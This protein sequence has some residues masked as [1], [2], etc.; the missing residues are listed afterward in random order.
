MRPAKAS[1]PLPPGGPAAGV[2]RTGARVRLRAWPLLALPF[3]AGPLLPLLVVAG[4]TGEPADGAGGGTGELTGEVL[5]SAAASLTDAFREVA[6]AFESANPGVTVTL[7]LAGSSA[8]RAQILEGAPVDVFAS[9]NLPVMEEVQDAGEAEG[10]PRVFTRN[11]LEI[12][13]PPGNPG[14]VSGLGDFARDELLVGLCAEAVP[15]GRFAREA[16]D[17]A[18][19]TPA[20]DTEEPDVRALLTKVEAGE[21]DAAMVYRTDVAAAGDRVEGIPIPEEVNVEAR[22]PIAVLTGAPNPAAARAFVDFVLSRAG[23]E[24]LRRHGFVAP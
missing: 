8:L 24:I 6:A 14:A 17:Q 18:G 16:L 7:N 4:C 12:A 9:A 20:L 15:C 19:V 11:V 3:R 21:L 2:P 5:V 23:V 13:V 22:Y 1:P 10:E